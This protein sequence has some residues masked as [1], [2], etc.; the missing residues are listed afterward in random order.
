MQ[1]FARR[2]KEG[3]LVYANSENSATSATQV[4][5]AL[6]NLKFLRGA[7]GTK[8]YKECGYDHGGNRIYTYIDIYA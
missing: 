7:N 3:T 5:V 6:D 4:R 8:L 2:V 1:E